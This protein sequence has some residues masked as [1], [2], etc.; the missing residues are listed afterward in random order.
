MEIASGYPTDSDSE[1]EA[2]FMQEVIDSIHESVIEMM[3]NKGSSSAVDSNLDE[4]VAHMASGLVDSETSYT[5]VS[6]SCSCM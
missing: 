3:C 6:F 2:M 5:T 1:L 4:I